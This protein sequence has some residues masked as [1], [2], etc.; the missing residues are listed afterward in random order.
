M[1]SKSITIIGA[2]L[3]GSSLA[4]LLADSGYL[5]KIYEKEPE[6][7]GNCFDYKDEE[8]YY[9]HKFGPHIFHT[10][11][12][13]VFQFISRFTNIIEIKHKVNVKIGDKEVPLPINFESI[14]CLF[15]NA[16]EIIENLKKTYVGKSKVTI[17]ELRKTNDPDLSKLADFIFENVFLN[18][19]VKM[20]GVKPEEINQEVINRVPIIL[21]YDDTYFPDDKY[22]GTPD[23]GYLDM[24]KKMLDHKSITLT[25]SFDGINLINNRDEIVYCGPIDELLRYEFGNLPYRSLD[26]RFEKIS[27]SEFQKRA[28]VNYPSDPL[29]TRI[30]EYKHF[31]GIK[32]NSNTVISREFPG[33]FDEDSKTHNKRFYSLSTKEALSKYE[34]YRKKVM[35]LYPNIHLLG[36]LAEYRYYDMDDVIARAFSL[37][38]EL[39]S[40]N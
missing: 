35:M 5:V 7:S 10:N 1:S 8:G 19:T 3:A 13:E 27:N 29:M 9:I 36:R 25:K 21:S 40:A 20:W 15:N 16:S 30:T 39:N 23:K 37:F 14:E 34:L 26:I 12:E 4:R 24:I 32:N 2:G 28:V 22:Q 31:F 38:K 18:Y 6:V 17:V 11:N 33:S